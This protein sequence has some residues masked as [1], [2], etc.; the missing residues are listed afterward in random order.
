MTKAES[1][2]MLLY[3]YYTLTLRYEITMKILSGNAI[4]HIMM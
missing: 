3:Q 1:K 4:L 2:E